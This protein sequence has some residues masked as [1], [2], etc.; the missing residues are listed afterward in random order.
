M[1]YTLF[2]IILGDERPSPFSINIDE[3]ET[4]DALKVKIKHENM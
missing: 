4:V 1:L 2:C 3:T